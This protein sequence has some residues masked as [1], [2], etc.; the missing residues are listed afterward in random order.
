[1]QSVGIDMSQVQRVPVYI[2]RATTED[3]SFVSSEI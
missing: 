1:M 2:P 3:A